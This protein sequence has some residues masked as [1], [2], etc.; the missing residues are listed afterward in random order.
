LLLEK[1]TS[2]FFTALLLFSPVCLLSQKSIGKNDTAYCDPR[3]NGLARPT[4][5][6]FEYEK[7]FDYKIQSTS[8]VDYYPDGNGAVNY[9]RRMK[10]KFKIPVINKNRFK[11]TYGFSYSHEEFRFKAPD[12]LQYAF[13]QSLEDKSLKSL[14]SDFNFIFS[15][16][17]NTFFGLKV[18]IS[19]N[20]DYYRSDA[21]L[22]DFVRV[23]AGPVFGIKKND[24]L[25]YGF[26]FAYSYAF[27]DPSLSPVVLY[28]HTFNEKWG[29]EAVLPFEAKI[30]YNIYSGG[31]LYA[32]AETRGASYNIHLDDPQ[33]SNNSSVELRHSEIKFFVSLHKEIY[34]FLWFRVNTG[35]RHNLNFNLAESNRN[36]SATNFFDRDYIIESDL[37]GAFFINFSLNIVAPKKW[38]N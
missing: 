5:I 31:L 32:G 38:M 37:E 13:Y 17:N 4:G 11:L 9:N 2:G 14:G 6:S 1:V 35:Y 29:V 3:V 18:N 22:L 24:N 15:R 36:R 34:D 10:F 23:S 21:T 16:K 25:M 8:N 28:Y 33:L 20:G 27:G 19:L 7:I 26:G 12:E 30:R